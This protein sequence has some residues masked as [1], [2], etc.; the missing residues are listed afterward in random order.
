[1]G[2]GRP[3]DETL[4]ILFP[5]LHCVSYGDW[6][7]FFIRH[8]FRA[9]PGRECWRRRAP[10]PGLAG[11]LWGVEEQS[12]GVFIGVN[13]F[14]DGSIALL[15]RAADDAR[16]MGDCF[17]KELGFLP[18]GHAW[19]LINGAKEAAERP[20]RANM[21]EAVRRA[22]RA[23]GPQG[24]AVVY[25]ASYGLEDC[26]AGQRTASSHCPRIRFRWRSSRKS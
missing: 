8:C 24:C 6:A 3:A 11:T 10:R 1:M 16:A 2:V 25:L 22:A 13:R 19:L 20:T 9:N 23:A 26:A 21:L 5:N 14:D 17:V 4:T 18:A 15:R 12:F 7:V